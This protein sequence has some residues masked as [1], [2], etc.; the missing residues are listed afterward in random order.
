MSTHRIISSTGFSA[1]LSRV[2]K[3]HALKPEPIRSRLSAVH[4][5]LLAADVVAHGR[6]LSETKHVSAK[7]LGEW[8]GVPEAIA[9]SIFLS[10]KRQPEI[11]P[12]KVEGMPVFERKT[13]YR[14]RQTG[15]GHGV[16]MNELR[17]RFPDAYEWLVK[18]HGGRTL[19]VGKRME[20][21]G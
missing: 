7:Q 3:K 14:R 1:L 16:V 15:Y 10:R 2:A 5:Y 19:Y 20:L 13:N 18:N 17:S 6:W 4:K 11:V 8:V 21:A 12:R 9:V